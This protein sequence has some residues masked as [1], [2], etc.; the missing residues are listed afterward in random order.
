MTPTTHNYRILK[1]GVGQQ[2]QRASQTDCTFFSLDSS[3]A[4][5]HVAKNSTLTPVFCT[6]YHLQTTVVHN[7]TQGFVYSADNVSVSAVT[8]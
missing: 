1:R 7:A 8:D 6:L 4:L 5:S 3:L 2:A